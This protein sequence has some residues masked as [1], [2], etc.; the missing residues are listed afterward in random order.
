MATVLVDG[1]RITYH[2]DRAWT[3][4]RAN[5]Y[6]VTAICDC[7]VQFMGLA[8]TAETARRPEPAVREQAMRHFGSG[9]CRHM[10]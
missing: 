1:H 3:G 4:N 9:Y 8:A 2:V 6:L 10:A 7:G 5:P